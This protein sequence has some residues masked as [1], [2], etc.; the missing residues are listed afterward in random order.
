MASTQDNPE[1]DVQ[2][3]EVSDGPERI[4]L[5]VSIG[6]RRQMAYAAGLGYRDS[7]L[8][9][10]DIVGFQMIGSDRT[11][12]RISCPVC[13]DPTKLR[14]RQRAHVETSFHT[15]LLS[16]GHRTSGLL[17]RNPPTPL[18]GLSKRRQS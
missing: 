17:P 3:I 9:A 2:F 13:P 10:Q 12:A 16:S 6:S 15:N 4:H 8:L 11:Y 18:R 5:H 7:G 14:F 1:G